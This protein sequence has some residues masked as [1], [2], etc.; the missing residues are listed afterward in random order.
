MNGC[1]GSSTSGK[2]LNPNVCIYVND[3]SANPRATNNDS[4]LGKDVGI[5]FVVDG[6]IVDMNKTGF[7]SV[8]KAGCTA[9][10]YEDAN[11]QTETKDATPVKGKTY[12][13]KWTKNNY[14]VTF[15]NNGHDEKPADKS[16]EYG[17]SVTDL[18]ELSDSTSEWVF[19]GW[20]MDENFKTKYDN[21]AITDNTTLYAKWH[22]YKSADLTVTVANSEYLVNEPVEVNVVAALGDDS[23]KVTNVVLEYDDNDVT[24]VMLNGK[25]LDKKEYTIPELMQ[26]MGQNREHKL[27]VTYGKA[28]T[29]TFG[30]VL[31]NGDK[32]VCE[33]GTDITVV[34]A[35]MDTTVTEDGEQKETYQANKPI[36]VEMNVTADKETF[37]QN[38]L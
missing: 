18:P 2:P 6:G 11:C 30:I 23:D 1:L 10:W 33:A 26:L 24:S 19:D 28:G 36:T 9:K 32:I 21:Q 34:Q 31:K 12:Y 27:N 8:T 25:V 4:G 22:E 3:E 7:D 5:V 29:H 38:T 14:T 13:A 37:K 35:L 17:D 15:N 20:Y 16:V